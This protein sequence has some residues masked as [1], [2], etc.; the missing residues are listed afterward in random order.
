MKPKNKMTIY[1]SLLTFKDWN[2]NIAATDKG[3]CYVGALNKSFEELTIWAEKQFPGALL[4]EDREELEPYVTELIEYFEGKRKNFSVPFDYQGTDF[5]VA[6]WNALC[7][8]PFGETRSYSDIANHI[9]K[10]SAVRAVGSAIGANPVLITVP[11]HRVVGKNGSL[12]GYR[13]GLEMKKQLLGLE[14]KY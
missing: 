7:E 10:P 6:V 8:I 12:T 3:L 14:Q 2:L 13:G 5:Q 9:D 1:W 4:V 11:C